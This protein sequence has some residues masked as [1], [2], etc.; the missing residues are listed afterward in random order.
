VVI[1]ASAARAVRRERHS[2]LCAEVRALRS[3][4]A[5]LVEVVER[6]SQPAPT[7]PDT[8]LIGISQAS[9]L[10]G[11]SG[12]NRPELAGTSERKSNSTHKHNAC[13]KHQ[14]GDSLGDV[15]AVFIRSRKDAFLK[16]ALFNV[17][18]MVESP[19]SGGTGGVAGRAP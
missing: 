16:V 13:C 14:K 6:M 15:T 2:G 11:Y 5:R 9:K 17:R 3:E 8:D 12:L 7:Q 1:R 10:S 4:V 19:G 18:L